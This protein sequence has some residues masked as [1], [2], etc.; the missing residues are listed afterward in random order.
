MAQRPEAPAQPPANLPI[1]GDDDF[2]KAEMQAAMQ[3]ALEKA[4][5][6]SVADIPTVEAPPTEADAP[7]PAVVEAAPPAT[8]EATPPPPSPA[9]PPDT[10]IEA[11]VIAVRK[12]YLDL[13]A[14]IRSYR[15]ASIEQLDPQR[16]LPTD[17]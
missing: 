7:V 17:W 16:D 3:R 11:E 2:A 5:K 4:G 12:A 13:A 15:T 14:D 9:L 8:I 6:A 10:E 1:G